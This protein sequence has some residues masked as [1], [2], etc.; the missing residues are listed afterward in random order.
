[1]KLLRNM[2]TFTKMLTFALIMIIAM[3]VIGWRGL[4]TAGKI[5]ISTDKMYSESLLGLFY[6]EEVKTNYLR[7]QNGMLSFMLTDDDKINVILD[8]YKALINDKFAAYELVSKELDNRET[9]DALKS[10]L[11]EYY[12]LTKEIT[13]LVK[14]NQKADAINLYITK[15]ADLDI[16][17][18]NHIQILTGLH[19][20]AAQSQKTTADTQFKTVT[21]QLAVIGIVVIIISLIIGFILARVIT[22]SIKDVVAIIKKMAVGDFT[23]KIKADRNDE[24]GTIIAELAKMSENL[25]HL[26][27]RIHESAALVNQDAKEI[28]V[29]NQ[30]LSQ[31]TQEQASTLEEIAS[32][33]EEINSSIQQMAYNSGH[34]NDLS[35]ETLDIVKEGEGSVNESKES[36][37]QILVSSKRISE[38]TKVVNQIAFQ[39]NLLALNAAVE[40]ARSGEHG[41]GFAVVAAEVR[42]LANRS[43]SSAKEI[44][45]LIKE[46]GDLIN[47]GNE[48]VH[49]SAQILEQI[50]S[51]TKKTSTEILT[52]TQAVQEQADASHQIQASIEQLNQVTQENAGMVVGISASS[53]SLSDVAGGLKDLIGEFKTEDAM[54]GDKASAETANLLEEA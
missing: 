41:R 1:M 17:L 22:R 18:R 51:N 50:V 28:A 4:T 23:T 5:K 2:K 21:S 39:T 14:N 32:T 37:D 9:L 29:G 43:A 3:A 33:I 19:E 25:S 6:I 40:A 34:V 15:A 10:T 13:D 44:E 45:K 11:E 20:A 26:I 36:M 54:K 49:K 24:I 31:R 47:H 8:G 27:Y 35:Q 53:Q 48:M 52:I 38:I 12:Q 16:A 30:E 7:Y 46:S 42:N